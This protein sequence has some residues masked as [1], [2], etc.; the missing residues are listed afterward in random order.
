MAC[1]F[2]DRLPTTAGKFVWSSSPAGGGIFMPAD[3][4]H[5][6]TSVSGAVSIR[7]CCPPYD[8]LGETIAMMNNALKQFGM[9]LAVA[10]IASQAALAIVHD[11]DQHVLSQGSVTGEF[12]RFHAL[13]TM[14]SRLYYSAPA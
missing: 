10:G 1:C 8:P 6:P 13:E 7:P 4:F 5:P 12:S 14:T 2:L 3:P 9:V 11:V